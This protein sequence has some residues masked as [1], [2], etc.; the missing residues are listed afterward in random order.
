M[1]LPREEGVAPFERVAVNA[2]LEGQVGRRGV[3]GG[4]AQS[5]LGQ[6]EGDELVLVLVQ[7]VL[8]ELQDALVVQGVPA[9]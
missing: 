1:S 3:A 9:H 4:I 6:R 5:R 8:V 2:H 7:G